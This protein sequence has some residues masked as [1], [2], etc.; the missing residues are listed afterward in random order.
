[1]FI[2]KALILMVLVLL[3]FLVCLYAFARI[4]SRSESHAS[5]MVI[6]VIVLVG[7]VLPMV[8]WATV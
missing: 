3:G 4:S 2:V 6:V 5:I 8:Y 1:M 7:I